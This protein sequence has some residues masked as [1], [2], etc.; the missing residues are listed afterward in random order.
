MP[1]D[2]KK[3]YDRF[4]KVLFLG[5]VIAYVLCFFVQKR[6]ISCVLMFGKKPQCMNKKSHNPKSIQMLMTIPTHLTTSGFQMNYTCTPTLLK[7]TKIWTYNYNCVFLIDLTIIF[8]GDSN[9]PY[10]NDYK[11]AHPSYLSPIFYIQII[12]QF[13]LDI[14]SLLTIKVH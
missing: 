14:Y 5:I 9:I 10:F 6:N 8:S 2:T 12:C 7:Y 1:K 3:C 13:L 11:I 4:L